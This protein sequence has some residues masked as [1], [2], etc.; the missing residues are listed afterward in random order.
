M[1]I[2]PSFGQK[3][4]NAVSAPAGSIT[5]FV[6]PTF[7]T[8]DGGTVRLDGAII[9]ERGGTHW[10]C[11]VEVK[12]G[13]TDLDSDQVNLY[14]GTANRDDFDAALTISNQIVADHSD[15]PVT[16]DGRRLM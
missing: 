15:S 2:V 12:T 4:L 1:A 5:T 11:L 7:K 10:S 16:V 14:L 9:I 13:S 3:I 6:E 8:D